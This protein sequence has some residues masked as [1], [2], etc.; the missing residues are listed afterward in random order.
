MT[1]LC[2]LYLPAHTCAV[3]EA[4]GALISPGHLPEVFLANFAGLAAGELGGFLSFG[5]GRLPNSPPALAVPILWPLSS[6]EAG[7]KG[8]VAGQINDSV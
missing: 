8:A 2:C 5:T 7:E 6:G 4:Q 3:T 1:K